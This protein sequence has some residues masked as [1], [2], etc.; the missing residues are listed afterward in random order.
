VNS[1]WEWAN[2]ISGCIPSYRGRVL[3][4]R[5]L[6]LGSEDDVSPR[7]VATH[8]LGVRFNLLGDELSLLGRF[9][10]EEEAVSLAG[11]LHIEEGTKLP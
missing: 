8:S 7:W 3:V 5:R 1:L 4:H 9:L 6:I 2:S 11:C 10:R